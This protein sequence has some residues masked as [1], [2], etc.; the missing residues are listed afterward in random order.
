MFEW[1]KKEA[2]VFTGVT[3]GVGGFGFGK[4]AAGG[5]TA[6][7]GPISAT[8]G[9]IHEYN[10]GGTKYRAHIFTTPGTFEYTSATSNQLEYMVIGGGG[11]GGAYNAGGGGSGSVTS[12]HPDMPAPLRGAALPVVGPVSYTVTVGRGGA[13]S[14]AS[15]SLYASDVGNPANV[16]PFAQ[17]GYQT[18]GRLGEPSSL[19]PQ[20]VARGGGGGGGFNGGA[21]P[22]RGPGGSG[23]GSAYGGTT[24]SGDAYTSNPAPVGPG[25]GYPGGDGYSVPNYAGGGGGGAGGAGD[26]GNPGTGDNSWG[27]IGLRI[28]IAGGDN[29]DYTTTG[30]RGP[31]GSYQWYAGGGGGGR[32]N[33]GPTSGGGPSN[34]YPIGNAGAGQGGG[35]SNV[36]GKDAIQGTGSG[37][38]GGGD[39][40]S[41]GGAGGSGIV[42]VR[43]QI[44]SI[45]GTTKATGGNISFYN[46]K[47]IHTF[48]QPG[49]FTV[50][51]STISSAEIIIVAGGGGGGGDSSPAIYGSAGGGAGEVLITPPAS[52]QTLPSGSPY[53]VTVGQGG[54]GGQSAPGREAGKQGE[55]SSFGSITASG[56]GGGGGGGSGTSGGSGGGGAQHG[57][58][59]AG[60]AGSKTAPADYTSYKN[61]G[62]AGSQPDGSGGG[63]GAGG[64][65]IAG[66]NGTG[67]SGGL[68]IQLPT[69]FQDPSQNIGM[70][71]PGGSR[72]WIGGGGGGA[73][74]GGVNAPGTNGGTGPGG[75]TGG[76]YAG[77][78]NAGAGPVP[79]SYLGNQGAEG[80]ANTGGGGGGSHLSSANPPTYPGA[81]GA[82][83][84]SGIVIIAYP[85]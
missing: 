76:P 44:P 56:G 46:G 72:F 26:P 78:G 22:A 54:Q 38:G 25:A 8:G 32:F 1:H 42:V 20:I 68:G 80:W 23:G 16:Y 34:A 31:G 24:G 67:G 57:S 17:A 40:Y 61:P 4:A 3:R 70:P 82:R 85:T 55:S 73:S 77:G 69:T 65:G 84:G 39:G 41:L 62:G 50:G 15:P 45:S 83:G 81:P 29:P 53:A 59:S 37:G 58:S 49:T 36:D 5:T 51:G 13:S 74:Y 21:G 11:S 75:N 2:P 43:Y 7:A 48:L 12:N 63:G 66:N 60:S 52:L 79:A 71:G 19:G 47:T 27:G 28:K 9:V 14:H 35:P 6:P 10:D 64:P 18:Q 30:Y 33:A